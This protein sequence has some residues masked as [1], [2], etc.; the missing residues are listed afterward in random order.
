[1]KKYLIVLVLATVFAAGC[2]AGPKGQTPADP[3][4]EPQPENQP[5]GVQDAGPAPDFLAGLAKDE[6]DGLDF[7][8]NVLERSAI[9][10]GMVF[11]ATVLIENKGGK[12]LFYTQGS[13][14]F[15]TPDALT[16]YSDAL[17][18][19]PPRDRLGI[20][21][22]DFVVNELKPGDSLLFKLPV[23]AIEPDPDFSAYAFELFS[24]ETYIADMEWPALQERYPG[25]A[26]AGPGAYTLKAYFR[27]SKSGGDGAGGD[28]AGGDGAGGDGGGDESDGAGGDD[29]GGFDVGGFDAFG[30]DT[31]YAEAECVVSVS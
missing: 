25:L 30:G 14:S 22:M 9:L 13:G 20:M 6:Y 18:A 21:T 2:T 3:S 31:G 7:S 10:P 24:E 5:P 15:E 29:V 12:T 1:M 26:A 17:Q 27:Y 11:Q 19:V 8:V 28:G 16:L 23:M 4:P